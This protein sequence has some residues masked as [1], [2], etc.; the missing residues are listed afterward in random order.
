MTKKPFVAPAATVLLAALL[1]AAAVPSLADPA[2]DR[3]A[4]EKTK[5]AA[6]YAKAEY[7]CHASALRKGEPVNVEC[8]AKGAAKLALSLIH[9]SEP[10]RPY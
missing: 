8:T 1:A 6:K 9:I 3:C 2:A 5:A 4:G 10:T 7:S